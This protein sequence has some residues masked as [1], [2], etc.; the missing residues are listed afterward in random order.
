MVQRSVEWWEI[1]MIGLVPVGVLLNFY[2]GR[3]PNGR[4]V[5]IGIFLLL[6]G[7]FPLGAGISLSPEGECPDLEEFVSEFRFLYVWHYFMNIPIS[8]WYLISGYH[9]IYFIIGC[10][11]LLYYYR[12]A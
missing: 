12:S 4:I 3:K 6:V 8:S 5:L 7:I 11:L 10:L 2:F 9:L 1:I